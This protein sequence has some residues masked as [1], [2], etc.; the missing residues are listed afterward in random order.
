MSNLTANDP[1]WTSWAEVPA[2][3]D[4]P[5]QNLPLGIF[6]TVDA[7]PRAA[8][9]IGDLVLDLALVAEAGLLT[10]TGI[11]THHFRGGSLNA[12]LGTGRQGIRALR[13]RLSVLLR[14]DEAVLRDDTPLR[15][16]AMIPIDRAVMHLPVQVGDYTDFYSSRQHA[17][18]VGC[19]FRDPKNALMPNWTHLPVG[20]HGRSSSIVVSGTPVRRPMGQYKPT[21]DAT[22][23]VFGATRQLDM[24][25][26]VAFITF[27]GNALGD[28][29]PTA[30]AEEY[31]VGL[32]LFN[33]WSAR[34][35]QAWEYVP[36]G[37]FL[38][39]NFCSSASPWIVLLDALEP[40]RVSG[41]RQDPP[42]LPYLQQQGDH[43]FDIALEASIATGDGGETTICR[44][45]FKHLYWSMAQ[46]LAHHTVNGCN[47]RC[48]DLMA[49]GTISGDSP[50][51]YGS[52]LELTW[53]GTGPLK[54]HDGSERKFLEDGDTLIMRGHAEKDGVRIGF[55]EVRGEVLPAMP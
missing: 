41:P 46:Q 39:K 9:R 16:K 36:L 26:E 42:V 38:G 32:V 19:M 25:L 43:H 3:S 10:G 52:L 8:S 47:V 34:D 24:E 22:A 15:S 21:P 31:I 28:R 14:S 48:G 17:Y 40:F 23:P 37:P 33:D 2:G 13:E 30:E 29:I 44:S 4:F 50:D 11:D 51:S 5:V 1:R 53:K 20:Y 49:S 35:I 18:N 55:G 45:N 54:V 27:S 12:L 6:S 7:G